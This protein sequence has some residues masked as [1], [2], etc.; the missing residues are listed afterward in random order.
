M[1]ELPLR[2]APDGV[3]IILQRRPKSGFVNYPLF[4]QKRMVDGRARFMTK[5]DM[6]IGPCACG[7]THFETEDWVQDFLQMYH[8]KV[9]SMILWGEELASRGMVVEIPGYWKQIRNWEYTSCDVL[10]GKC[11]CSRTHR[12]GTSR[13]QKLLKRHQAVILNMPP[14]KTKT[15]SKKTKLK[16]AFDEFIHDESTQLDISESQVESRSNQPLTDLETENYLVNEYGNRMELPESSQRAIE[17]VSAECDCSACQRL[18]EDTRRRL[19]REWVGASIDMSNALDRNVAKR[20][21]ARNCNTA[22]ELP[23]WCNCASCTGARRDTR[24]RDSSQPGELTVTL[25][26]SRSSS[27]SSTVA[28]RPSMNP[29]AEDR[30]YRYRQSEDRMY[31]LT[32]ELGAQADRGRIAEFE[33][34]RMGTFFNGPTNEE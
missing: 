26:S 27:A 3:L 17:N 1:P 25:N 14:Q 24:D 21:A 7:Y 10:V 32:P 12:A 6:L 30:M 19:A 29:Q 18:Q 5:C 31:R 23:G 22:G 15:K 11:V 13:V 2:P 9:E 4:F 33:N 20:W 8:C 28:A 16:K 34:I